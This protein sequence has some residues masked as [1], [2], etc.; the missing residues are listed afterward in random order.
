VIIKSLK[1]IAL[2][3]LFQ[4][5]SLASWFGWL[6]IDTNEKAF[7]KQQEILVASGTNL[8]S[9]NPNTT[10]CLRFFHTLYILYIVAIDKK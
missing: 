9:H 4:E 3:C 8:I 5:T 7:I 10:T 2:I 6:R 1:N